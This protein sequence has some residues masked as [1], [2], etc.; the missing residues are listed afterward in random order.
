MRAHEVAVESAREQVH[1]AVGRRGRVLEEVLT[2]H[3]QG[4]EEALEAFAGEEERCVAVAEDLEDLKVDEHEEDKDLGQ[5]RQVAEDH[6][7]P[8]E[9]EAGVVEHYRD[10]E[11]GGELSVAAGRRATST[12]ATAHSG[13]EM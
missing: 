5:R 1:L 12:W 9:G 8:A 7:V 2:G 4:L 13:T 3:L 6:V 10:A 11:E